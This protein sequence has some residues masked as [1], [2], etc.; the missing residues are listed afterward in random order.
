MKVL[1]YRGTRNGWQVR[2]VRSA[3]EAHRFLALLNRIQPDFIHR[4][5]D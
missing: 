5:G 2:T 1:T 4:T 3:A